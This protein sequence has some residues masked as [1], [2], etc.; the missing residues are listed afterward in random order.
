MC[1]MLRERKCYFEKLNHFVV[2]LHNP[3]HT[4]YTDSYS[5]CQQI[6]FLTVGQ[7]MVKQEGTF[8]WVRFKQTIMLRCCVLNSD[9]QT[10]GVLQ[11]GLQGRSAGTDLWPAAGSPA[12]L[13]QFPQGISTSYLVICMCSPIRMNARTCNNRAIISAAVPRRTT[14][15]KDC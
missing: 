10:P 14:C 11:S 2:G 15:D 9:H 13:W 4:C 12:V 6:L 3:K 5:Y 1:W 8:V 7:Q